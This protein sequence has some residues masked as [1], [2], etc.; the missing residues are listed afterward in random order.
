MSERLPD[1]HPNSRKNTICIIAMLLV[2]VMITFV[3]PVS[4][5]GPNQNDLNSGGDLP[6]NTT[7]NITT[8]QFSGSYSG[9][10]ELD[11]NDD[12]DWLRVQVGSNK[13]LSAELSFNSTTT[14]P[15]G[16]TIV[17][18]FDLAIYDTNLS[19]I[20][21]S[22]QSN[23]EQVSTNNSASG[24]A[25]HGGLVYI[26]IERF[27]G[28][29]DWTLTIWLWA[30]STQPPP[31]TGDPLEVND[32]YANATQVGTLP[33]GHTNLDIH[34]TTDQD[35]FEVQLT[36]GTTYYFDIYF[37]D[38]NGDIDMK[39]F[40]STTSITTCSSSFNSLE[41]ATSISDNESFSHNPATTGSYFFC[42]FGYSSAI[43]SYSVSIATTPGG[44]AGTTSPTIFTTITSGST[45]Q[46][47]LDNLLVNDS[48]ELTATLQEFVI[49][50]NNVTQYNL[51][52]SHTATSV[53]HVENFTWSAV[54]AESLYL[55]DV[56][57]YHS[58]TYV[59]N[60]FDWIYIERLQ[61]DV[62]AS[63]TGD[64]I[65]TNLTIGT[66]YS[67]EWHTNDTT[68]N[69]T[70]GDGWVNFTATA[71]THTQAVTWSGPS[72]MNDH[73]FSAIMYDGSAIYGY[74]E[75]EFVPN[76]PSIEISTYTHDAN[77]STNT[78]DS[79]G[80]DMINGN[81]YQYL[82]ELLD[83]NGTV[84]DD[85]GLLTTTATSP[86]MALPTWTYTTP[87]STGMYCINAE[88]YT[89]TS[90]TMLGSDYTCFN[91][92]Y[93]EDNDGIADEDDLCWGTPIGS[94]VDADGCA[95]SQKDSDGDG[96]TDDI[97]VFPFESSQWED[98][99]GDG[100][101]DNPSGNL[102]D[103]FPT[104]STQWEDADGD[105]HGDNPWGTDG[106]LFPSDPTQWYDVDGDGWG[107]NQTGNYPDKFPTDST[108]WSDVD[109]DGYGD[110]AAGNNADDFVNDPTQ[111]QDSD[112]D[113]YGDNASG[114]NPDA[115]P[116]EQS[117]H[118]DSDGD[119][120]GDN[121]NGVNGD[122]FPDDSTQHE[123]SDGDG[124]G[125]DQLGNN[126]DA[127]P[128]DATQWAD[129]DGD[130]YGDNP[131]GIMP[132]MFPDEITQWADDDGDG[133]GDAANGV[134]GDRCLGT[135][136]GEIV[137][138]FGCSLSQMDADMDGVSDAE[139]Q[140]DD[141]PTGEAADAI[142]CSPS[143]LDSDGDGVMN[144][145]DECD[146][147]ALNAE[148]DLKGCADYQ[149]DSDNDM[150]PDSRDNCLFTPIGA[151]VDGN[152]CSE[153]ERD[154]DA[155]GIFDSSD[156]CENTPSDEIADGEGCSDSQLDGD[157][158]GVMND[159]DLCRNSESDADVDE[160]GCSDSQRDEDRDGYSDADD[161]CLGTAVAEIV[162]ENGCSRAQSDS[163][164]DLVSDSDDKCP[165]TPEMQEADTDGCSLTQLDSDKDGIKDYLDDCPDTLPDD[166][167]GANG[168]A[169]RQLDSDNDGVSDLD[170]DF[171][172]DP[173]ISVDSDGDGVA[174]IHDAFP[175]DSLKSVAVPEESNIINGTTVAIVALIA[176]IGVLG[177][178]VW[179]K[180]ESDSPFAEKQSIDLATEM[181]YADQI[182]TD[183]RVE[184]HE[185]S[186][187][188][189][190]QW[191][192]ENGV[193]WSRAA[194]GTTYRYDEMAGEWVAGE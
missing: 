26:L 71:T 166:I 169:L 96:Y 106:D 59:S 31:T 159:L 168:C 74:H 179:N 82:L 132:D 124:Y 93:D 84:L 51:T 22:W 97:D 61:N 142:G 47:E 181:A 90:S 162:D 10:G 153:D 146:N 13:G 80:V 89:T 48:Y 50:V 178:M 20:D 182:V 129:R 108:Q 164:G 88:L 24:A 190:T 27:D 174:D 109:G 54:D 14:F 189:A 62:T 60:S 150:I 2:S 41:S 73:L 23:P 87:S 8:Y 57:L 33:Y 131:S 126:P 34:S 7:V 122:D 160:D 5:I 110:N 172:K 121:P 187:D 77:S 155:D 176:V 141:T 157:D 188:E 140:C 64:L 171:P 63:T 173:S 112:G 139:D 148:V 55:L 38:A 145:W 143:Q 46:A 15:N 104:D 100:Y 86:G 37:I 147:T 81:S 39:L 191:V 184:N 52:A 70:L 158:D 144:Q 167:A 85:N 17:N 43:N 113:G 136:S 180:P 66:S 32:D 130:G 12:A 45:A 58:G 118:A 119:G 117:Q 128:D 170:D 69:S 161:S 149:R 21:S 151:Q 44:G 95:D 111:W 56:E 194:D 185:L 165:N 6:D 30:S 138:E 83:A 67:I 105:G 99:D 133:H 35:I 114:N 3:S 18:D 92:F 115:F 16:T 154:S 175:E 137:D 134:N 101:G 9:T 1:P 76:L 116:N 28:V 42:V 75:F 107:D 40:D 94:M 192:D 78:V 91:L 68:T 36:A 163:D 125:D 103:A 79:S 102:S 25:S 186:S 29:G 152:G 72:T 49:G 11:Y 4:A 120:Y 123:D 135:P 183:Q 193:N 98:A 177:F 65:A 156:S 127:F 53:T 19:L